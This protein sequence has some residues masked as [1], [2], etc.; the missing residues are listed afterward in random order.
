[1]NNNQLLTSSFAPIVLISACGLI[2]PPLYSRLGDILNRIRAFHHQKIELLK[3]LHE[4]EIEE[5]HMLLTM[6]DSQIEQVTEK[7]RMI[8]RGLH[9]L[10]EAT[11]AFL[12]CSV[13]AGAA[14][15]HQWLGMAAL[16]VGVLGVVLF[17]AGLGWAMRELSHS[18]RPLE[19][20]SDRL[21]VVATH[22]LRKSKDMSQFK[23]AESA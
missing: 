6:L 7:A 21:K 23:I 10:L 5:R 8:K 22:Y 11:A 18:L 19:D 12:V 17:L 9:C 13:L 16:G 3:N 14:E 1:M 20:E 4:H 2:T 15:L